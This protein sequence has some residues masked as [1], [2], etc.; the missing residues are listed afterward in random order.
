MEGAQE[1]CLDRLTFEEGVFDGDDDDDDV[2]AWC[3]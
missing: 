3:G 1:S 2:M